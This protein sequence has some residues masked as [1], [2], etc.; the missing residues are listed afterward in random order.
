MNA[1]LTASG[2]SGGDVLRCPCWL[3]L[4]RGTASSSTSPWSNRS[5]WMGG[6]CTCRAWRTWRVPWW[7]GDG[8]DP[9]SLPLARWFSSG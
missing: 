8:R 2:V 5:P 4:L 6:V 1:A 7:Y 3:W 9:T